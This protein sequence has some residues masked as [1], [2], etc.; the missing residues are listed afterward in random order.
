MLL[1]EHKSV[2]CVLP[3]WRKVFSLFTASTCRTDFPLQHSY[4]EWH[5]GLG[6]LEF[7]AAPLTNMGISVA[8]QQI[9]LRGAVGQSSCSLCHLALPYLHV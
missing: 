4:Q 2:A 1:E 5:W 7:T 8:G 9:V 3:R 6:E